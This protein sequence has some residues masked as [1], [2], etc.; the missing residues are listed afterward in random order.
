MKELLLIFLLS[1][2]MFAAVS[3]SMQPVSPASVA[4]SNQ[5]VFP[6]SGHYLSLAYEIES[7][8]STQKGVSFG[9]MGSPGAQRSYYL[10][11]QASIVVDNQKNSS[12][13]YSIGAISLDFSHRVF[14]GQSSEVLPF[15]DFG[16]GYRFVSNHAEVPRHYGAS[17]KGILGSIGFRSYTG[18]ESTDLRKGNALSGYIGLGCFFDLGRSKGLFIKLGYR[19]TEKF[20]AIDESS[21]GRTMNNTTPDYALGYNTYFTN[22]SFVTFSIGILIGGKVR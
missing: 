3:Q 7:G 22:P 12:Y 8:S 10:G 14:M 4:K 13:E 20:E 19:L 5:K 6:A 17:A 2:L 9:Y 15:I 21:L 16:L 18:G 11:V 1:G